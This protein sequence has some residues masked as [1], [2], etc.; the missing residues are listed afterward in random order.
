[1]QPGEV[2]PD[3]DRGDIAGGCNDVLDPRLRLRAL[4][5]RRKT[6]GGEL[7]ELPLDGVMDAKAGKVAVP[8]QNP[9]GPRIER[10]PRGLPVVRTVAAQDGPLEVD[11]RSWNVRRD[12]RHGRRWWR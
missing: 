5:D 11:E 6:G 12:R 8:A 4:V 1:M 7:P 3:T 2:P 10:E 9:D